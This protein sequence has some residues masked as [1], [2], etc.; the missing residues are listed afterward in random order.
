[1]RLLLHIDERGVVRKAHV[2]ES[3]PEGMFDDAAL[4]AWTDVRFSPALKDGLAVK[5]R[6]LLEISFSP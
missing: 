5:S 1:V 2:E 6:K 4:S 3:L